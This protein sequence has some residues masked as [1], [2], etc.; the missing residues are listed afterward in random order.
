MPIEIST[1]II[2]N[3]FAAVIN[4]I[5]PN[6]NIYDNPN[7]QGTTYPAW[8]IVHRSPVELQRHV[9]KRNNGNRY[10]ITFQIDLWY[11]LQQNITR[12]FDQYTQIAEQLAYHLQYLPIFGSDAVTQVYDQSWSLE[13][14]AL[15]YS[16]TI[17]L[18]V[19]TDEKFVFTPMEVIYDFETYIKGQNESFV[20]FQNAAHPEFDPDYPK[21][22]SVTTGRKV[23]LPFVGGT[24]ED[25]DYQWKPVGW[26]LGGFGE[27]IQVD[28]NLTA[29]LLWES[30]NKTATITFANSHPEF[31][32]E[33]P[34]D[35]TANKG[36]EI[37]LPT[38]DATIP[39]GPVDWNTTSWDI[40]NF[41][42]TYILNEDAV[43]TLQWTNQ[44]VFFDVSFA[45]TKPEFDVDMPSSMHVARGNHI[46]LPTVEGTYYQDGYRWNPEAWSIGQ[47]GEELT[48]ESD[49][50]ANL[51]WS[52][53]ELLTAGGVLTET[54]STSVVVESI[55]S[56]NI[57][58]IKFGNI[59]LRETDIPQTGE[60]DVGTM[61]FHEGILS[62]NTIPQTGVVVEDVQPV[63]RNAYILPGKTNAW[64]ALADFTRT[65]LYDEAGQRLSYDV[66][67]TYTVTGLYRQDGS[68]VQYTS[69][70][71]YSAS[72]YL[73]IEIRGME[74]NLI[75]YA[76][77]EEV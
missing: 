60:F 28:K 16:T 5:Q 67:N 71:M 74:N 20:T 55:D 10:L 49:L 57:G 63:V 38:V 36:T 27:L 72:G 59:D 25:E 23:N 47:F 21:A 3:S 43:A 35:I 6:A 77:Y 76:E 73:G 7:Q 39:I 9:G 15:K 51:I 52:K 14:N 46:I 34:A 62:D 4:K 61:K 58:S 40:G 48:V 30:T 64:I 75:C 8:F 41:G 44:D 24:F 53:V 69:A 66:S 32:V 13:L 50:N 1:Q 11:M 17:K 65:D 12:L 45:N 42:A 2:H 33:L 54:S 22:L 19:Y 37:T 31:S 18:R 26:S 29:E 68:P 56:I 70:W